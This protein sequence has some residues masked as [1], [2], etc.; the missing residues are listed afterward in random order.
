MPEVKELAGELRALAA[1]DEMIHCVP[2]PTIK[3]LADQAATILDRLDREA[4]ARVLAGSGHD[5]CKPGL[6]IVIDRE[7]ARADAI[8]SHIQ[9]GGNAE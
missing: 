4:M 3:Q 7:L 9:G 2:W 6:C 5:H 8:I 1:Q